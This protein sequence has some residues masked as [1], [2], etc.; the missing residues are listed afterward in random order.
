MR[1]SAAFEFPT[2]PAI[3]S[4]TQP[5][6]LLTGSTILL[7]AKRMNGGSRRGAIPGIP[8]KHNALILQKHP[9][10]AVFQKDRIHLPYN[11]PVESAP[12]LL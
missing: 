2:V 9:P 1:A 8:V 3:V 10:Q 4:D 12:K 7:E 5:C 11:S 6:T